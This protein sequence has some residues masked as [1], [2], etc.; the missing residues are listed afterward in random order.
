MRHLNANSEFPG[1]NKVGKKKTTISRTYAFFAVK[2]KKNK[3]YKLF[4]SKT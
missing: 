1:T 3:L 2:E 4:W